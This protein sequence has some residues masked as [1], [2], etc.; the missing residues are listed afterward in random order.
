[1]IT[2]QNLGPGPIGAL[3]AKDSRVYALIVLSYLIGI[4]KG[5]YAGRDFQSK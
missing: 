1:M 2:S 4:V 5:V 3:V